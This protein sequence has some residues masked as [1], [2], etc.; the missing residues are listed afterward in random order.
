VIAIAPLQFTVIQLQNIPYLENI[1]YK[2]SYFDI[3]ALLLVINFVWNGAARKLSPFERHLAYILGLFCLVGIF[4]LAKA[5]Y[6]LSLFFY[7]L[8]LATVF[9][10]YISIIYFIREHSLE[11]SLS[12]LFVCLWILGI[13]PIAYALENPDFVKS[14]VSLLAEDPGTAKRLGSIYN[15][16]NMT[17]HTI[18]FFLPIFLGFGL[19]PGHKGTTRLLLLTTTIFLGILIVFTGSRGGMITGT[20]GLFM[21]ALYVGRFSLFL[22]PIVLAG[23]FFLN[24][25]FIMQFLYDV[26]PLSIENRIN[27]I[28]YGLETL[29][30]HPIIGIGL[31]QF[32]THFHNMPFYLAGRSSHN[33]YL[34]V[35]VE[36]GILGF[37]VFLTFIIYV[38]KE[39]RNHIDQTAKSI[40]LMRG[41]VFSSFASLLCSKLFMGG[42][43]LVTWWIA[44][45]VIIGFVERFCNA[46]SQRW[47]RS[48]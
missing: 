6:P 35:L 20:V 36:T 26:R 12:A 1:P 18:G 14:T 7:L 16:P 3:I 2:I 30:E 17:G 15:Q 8:R 39:M 48:I 41:I 21:L 27:L 4:S 38:W 13:F 19:L 47:L 40:R 10:I 33:A 25:A 29:L 5:A 9:V 31:R 43:L 11:Q 23:L 32:K 42:L 37:G 44:L 22:I 24:W 34:E 28:Y 45:A 46:D